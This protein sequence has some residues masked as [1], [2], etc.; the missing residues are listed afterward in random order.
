M[1]DDDDLWWS[2]TWC[3]ENLTLHRAKNDAENDEKK[4]NNEART[5]RDYTSLLYF[6]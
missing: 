2:V 1:M 4:N 6:V 5:C 3:H